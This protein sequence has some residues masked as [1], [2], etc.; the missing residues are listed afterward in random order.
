MDITTTLPTAIAAFLR[1]VADTGY[2]GRP[3][4][5]ED[6][7]HDAGSCTAGDNCYG[8]HCDPWDVDPDEEHDTLVDLVSEA[9]QLLG[10]PDLYGEE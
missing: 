9:R 1:K 7:C 3:C 2:D 5:H 10:L 6:G 4:S 8:D